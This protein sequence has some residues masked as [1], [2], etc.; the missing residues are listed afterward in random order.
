MSQEGIIDVVGSNPQIPTTFQTNSGTA[1]PIGNI[2]E[3]LGT[4]VAAGTTPHR[5]TGSGNTVTS[6]IQR[7]QAFASSVAA[8]VGLASFDSASFSVDTNGFVTFVG[9]GGFV[10]SV[11][12][13][14]NRITSTGGTTPV[15]DISAS[16]VGQASITTLGT[17][18]TGVWNGTAVD[19]THGGTAQT[20]WAQGD[21]MYASAANTL[22]KLTKDTNATRYLSNT[23]TTN[24]PAWAQV[25]LANGVTGNLPVTN[26]NSGTS[27]S[28]TTFW[29][30]D[31]TWVAP[32]GTGVTSVT[33]TANRITSTGGTTPVIDIAATYV[34]QSSITTLGTIT[35]GVWNGT[36]IAVANGGTS[37]TSQTAYSLVAGGT[38]NTGAFQAVG[39][40]AV[41]QV[42]ASAG[43]STLPAF[44][45]TPSVTSVTVGGGNAI[46]TYVEGTWTPNIQIAG[47]S[48][49]ITYSTQAGYYSRI[50]NNVTIYA[51]IVLSSKG[52]GAGAV[53]ISNLPVATGSNPL[54]GSIAIGYFTQLTAVGYTALG[55]YFSDAASTVGKFIISGSGVSATDL[56]A[57]Q[58]SNTFAVLITGTYQV[59]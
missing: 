22:S 27:A 52:V 8:R 19:A 25:N 48:T 33:G 56:A 57:T 18:T 2:L 12:G 3:I 43:T 39:P 30:G 15:I 55:M 24:N 47:S 23:G 40:V 46:S 45:A 26:L 51:Y 59:N 16:Y 29:R 54:R 17:I 41:G 38:T 42:L 20:S 34:G 28:A 53:T 6:E 4:T 44:T 49:G 9:G 5:T 21:L 50:N 10:T 37:N 7:S 11:S 13:T 36:A 32:A 1:T 35:T 58:I 14:A 31:G